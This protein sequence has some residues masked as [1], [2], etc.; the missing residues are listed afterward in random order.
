MGGP[1]SAQ[2]FALAVCAA[3]PLQRM[4]S[5]L[6]LPPPATHKLVAVTLTSSA[7][8]M[9]VGAD[10]VMC[11]ARFASESPLYTFH[12]AVCHAAYTFGTHTGFL[13]YHGA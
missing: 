6:L 8:H 13:H 1:G 4:R 3:A 7:R 11:L 12:A 5:A 2:L 10:L 9:W